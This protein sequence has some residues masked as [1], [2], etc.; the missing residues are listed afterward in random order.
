MGEQNWEMEDCHGLPNDS[1]VDED[2]PE[3]INTKPIAHLVLHKRSCDG[4]YMMF[5]G[6]DFCFEGDMSYQ[7]SKDFDFMI[8]NSE[9]ED[10]DVVLITKREYDKLVEAK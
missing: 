1:Y 6:S 7:F 2:P 5:E 8:K 4:V 3:V 9:N 10:L